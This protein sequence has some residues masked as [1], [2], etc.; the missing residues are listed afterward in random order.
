MSASE[1][2]GKDVNEFMTCVGAE[3]LV[4]GVTMPQPFNGNQ[5][6]IST[7]R[8]I[9]IYAG[10]STRPE[11]LRTPKTVCRTVAIWTK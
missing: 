6:A 7:I 8:G 3:I 11:S 1:L 5:I 9:E 2:A 4:N 10:P